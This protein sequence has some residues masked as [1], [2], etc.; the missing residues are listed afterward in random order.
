MTARGP[1]HDQLHALLASAPP[2]AGSLVITLFGDI[3]SQQGGC[4]WLGSLVEVMRAFG[5]NERQVRTAVFRLVQDDWLEAERRGR[6]SYYRLSNNGQRQYARAAA[7]IYASAERPWNGEWLLVMPGLAAADTRDELRRRLGWLGF[8]PLAN[9]VL[10]NPCSSDMAVAEVLEELELV[11]H[12]LVWRARTDD[13][14]MLRRLVNNAWHLD[15]LG[16]QYAGF[17]SRFAP[18]VALVDD[19][20]PTA[21]EAFM[22]RVLLI[23]EYRRLLL[24]THELPRVLLPRTWPGGEALALVVSLY[25]RVRDAASRHA[26]AV[27][28]NEQGP[29][30][31][32]GP[33]LANRF[34]DYPELSGSEPEVRRGGRGNASKLLG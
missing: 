21:S 11:D 9:G 27:L 13:S 22:L 14:A 23:H 28:E 17:V 20:R 8:A 26:C 31:L 30:G 19:G 6:R 34:A 4:V 2:R 24:R 15:D 7:R 10:A 18:C 3:V 29:L 16:K 5:L 32:P 25:R 33:E 12:V 1:L